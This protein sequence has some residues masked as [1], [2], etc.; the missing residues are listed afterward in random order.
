MDIPGNIDFHTLEDQANIFQ[1]SPQMMANSHDGSVATLEDAV[2]R[3]ASAELGEQPTSAQVQA[4][5][6][7]LR[8]LTGKYHGTPLTAPSP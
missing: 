8:T 3:M 5:A 6:V 7:F 4:I 1:E 2:R